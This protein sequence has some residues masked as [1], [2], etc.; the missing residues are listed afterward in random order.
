MTSSPQITPPGT[1]PQAAGY[2]PAF[3]ASVL[4]DALAHDCRVYSITGLQGT[5]KSTIAA[6]LVELARE[7]DLRAVALSID[8]FYLDHDARVRLG[9]EVHPLLATRGPPGSHD[10]ALAC[11]VVDA[12]REGRS[13]RLP[14]FDKIADRR[15]PTAEWPVVDGADLVLF[16]GWFQKVPAQ[17]PEALAEPVNALERDEDPHG[18][19][20]TWCNDALARDYAPLWSRLDR[21]LFLQGPGFDQVPEWRWQQE[22]TLQAAHPDRAAMT[23]PQV[24][25]FVQFFERVSR[26]GWRLLPAIADRTVRLDAHRRPVD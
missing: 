18:T 15:L 7:R 6:Q 11:E 10:V 19:W 21:L 17:S 16:E 26:H 9:R 13:T 14:R 20:R 1:A 22:C 23:R 3:V 8:D 12:L 4:N 5:G 2:T 24:M 25:R